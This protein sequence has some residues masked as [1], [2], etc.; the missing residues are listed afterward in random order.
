MTETLAEKYEQTKKLIENV[1]RTSFGLDPNQNKLK[2]PGETIDVWG[3]SRGSATVYIVL[4]QATETNYIQVFSQVYEL[5]DSVDPDIYPKLLGYNSRMEMCSVA[6]AVKDKKVI[7]KSDRTTDD[8]NEGELIDIIVKVGR[9][10]DKY[11]DI[12]QNDYGKLK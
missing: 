1:F 6:F 4:T 5:S 3:L 9:L 8:L 7:L 10:A 2:S 11:D 12:L